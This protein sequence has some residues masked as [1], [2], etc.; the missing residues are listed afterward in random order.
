MKVAIWEATLAPSQEQR[1]RAILSCLYRAASNGHNAERKKLSEL[2]QRTAVVCLVVICICASSESHLRLTCESVKLPSLDSFPQFTPLLHYT[3]TVCVRHRYGKVCIYFALSHISK[4]I[5]LA[6][7]YILATLFS[8]L[9]MRRHRIL[10]G[11]ETW[12]KNLN[13]LFPHVT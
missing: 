2:P 11:F 7:V 9:N 1:Q 12:V 10:P 6:I 5:P 8:R 4:K 3:E 13:S